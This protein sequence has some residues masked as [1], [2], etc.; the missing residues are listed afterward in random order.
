MAQLCRERD[1][2]QGLSLF[3]PGS[4]GDAMFIVLSGTVEVFVAAKTGEKAV[5]GLGP[6]ASFGELAL[7]RHGRRRVGTRAKTACKLVEIRRADFNEV[8][9]T[10]PQACIKLMLNIFQTVERRLEAVQ[11]DLLERL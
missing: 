6:G 2:S 3:L 8:L 10:K 7:V 4:Q 11:G 5:T 9:K 1:L